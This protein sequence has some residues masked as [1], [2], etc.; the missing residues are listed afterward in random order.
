[1]EQPSVAPGPESMPQAQPESNTPTPETTV[2][3]EVAPAAPEVEPARK[4]GAAQGDAPMALPP[5][6]NTPVVQTPAPA[7]QV[8]TN[9]N[10]APAIADDVDVIEKEW[11]DKAKGIVQSTKHDPYQQNQQVSV[12]KAKYM[13]KRYG[14]DIKL[15][16]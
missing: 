5:V 2:T 15:S 4:E 9:D 8:D 13:K 6:Q 3:P 14:K 16:S 7:P 1:M 12:L 11:V 10:D